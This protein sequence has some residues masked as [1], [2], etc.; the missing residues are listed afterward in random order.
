MTV[1]SVIRL[2]GGQSAAYDRIVE[3]LGGAK[4]QHLTLG[5][6]AGTGK[7]TLIAY[8]RKRM[9]RSMKFR[10]WS[11]AFCCFTGKAANVLRQKL[12]EQAALRYGD[13]CSTIHALIYKAVLDDKGNAVAWTR[14]ATDELTQDLIIVDEASM[15]NKD[16]WE[17]LRSYS[18]PILVVGD[19]GQLPPIGED[20][21]LMADPELRLERIVRQEADNPIIQLSMQ[22]RE[23]GDIP[24][25]EYGPHVRKVASMPTQELDAEFMHYDNS[26]M[27]LC[28]Y[29]RTRVAL[30]KRIRAVLNFDQPEPSI[31]E[32]VICLRNNRK[33]NIYNGMLGTIE[34]IE[35]RHDD[36]YRSE[37]RLDGEQYAFEGVISRHQFGLP[38][39]LRT[40]EDLARIGIDDLVLK[41]IGDLFDWGY[42][43]TVHKAQGGEAK[44]VIVFEEKLP[45]Y[46]R[47][48]WQRWLYTAVT[49]SSD[50]LLIIGASHF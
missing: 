25:G 6:Y 45:K 43:L 20:F 32:R 4:K 1:S 26:T 40:E 22:I 36:W 39:T 23:G 42:A 27:V 35:P 15:V 2:T 34:G 11:V 48:T 7:T 21:N 38:T 14:K 8:L 16:I 12:D 10:K 24:V 46:D 9:T 13:S 50:S 37:I 28:G 29:N 3:W 19:H 31:G 17:D 5:G 49:R 47:D 30:N 41:D 44:N 18:K 33:E